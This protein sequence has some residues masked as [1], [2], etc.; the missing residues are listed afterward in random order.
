MKIIKKFVD[1]WKVFG[2]KHDWFRCRKKPVI[3]KAVQMDKDFKV[4]TLEGN[5]KGKKGDY[6]LEGIKGEVYLCRKDIFEETY[7]KLK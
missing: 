4:K 2:T 6:L 1:A 7:N 3:I 5:H